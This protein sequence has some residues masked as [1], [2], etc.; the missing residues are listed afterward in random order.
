MKY[1]SITREI[2][3]I[4][5]IGPIYENLIKD[6]AEKQ[7]KKVI[8]SP[9]FFIP[10]E[11]NSAFNIITLKIP[12]FILSGPGFS[13]QLDSLYDA[14][15]VPGK[16]CFC[17]KNINPGLNPYVFRT[18]SGYGE[19]SAVSLHNEISTMLKALFNIEL[20]SISIQSLQKQ[21][22]V[23]EQLRRLVRNISALRGGNRFLL[24]NSELSLIFETALILPPETA[25][26]YITPVLEQMKKID[27]GKD[28]TVIRGMLYG[29][30]CI[31][32]HVADD[33]EESGIVIIEDDSC[34]GR[35]LFDISLNADSEY[36]FYELLDAYSYRPLTPCI[37]PVN[38]R[39]ELLYKL[40]KNYDIETVIFFRDENCADSVKDIDYLRIRMMRDGIDP[41][42]V[43]KN[44]YR[45]IVADYVSR[46]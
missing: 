19:D 29:G 1:S 27:P 3:K 42:V 11:I 30:K 21:T 32:S 45:E 6:Y 38:E 10:P 23:Y 5:G 44:N 28:D 15:I 43:D 16:E 18:P 8:S 26:E 24:S 22:S 31:P 14:V 12:E 36:I 17:G 4:A 25:I 46:L 7:G 2:E 35:R 34:T 39:Y 40:L 9:C 33:I 41:L 13:A 37:R 20:K